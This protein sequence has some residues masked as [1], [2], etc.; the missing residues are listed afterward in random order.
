MRGDVRCTTPTRAT[1]D[2][3]RRATD[4]RMAVVVLDLAL[5]AGAVSLSALG[6]FLATKAGWP[7]IRQVSD[8]A[9]LADPRSLSP[10]ETLLRLIWRLDARLPAP[11]S[12]WPVADDA[13]TFIGRPD[14]LCEELAVVGEYDGADHRTRARHRDDVRRDELFRRVGLE[15]F[16]VVGA[17]LDDISLVVE[18]MR[19]AVRRAQTSATPRTWRIRRSPAPVG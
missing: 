17:D 4:L 13:G 11:R 10:K 8:A 9:V 12:N 14:L 15:P 6:E 3:A 19:A 16:R 7:G 18:R 1:F 2:A 5:A